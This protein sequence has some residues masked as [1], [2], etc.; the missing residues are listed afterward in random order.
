MQQAHLGLI[1]VPLGE[2]LASQDSWAQAGK[3]ERQESTDRVHS[4]QEFRKYEA[5]VSLEQRQRYKDDFNAEYEGYQNLYFKIDKII[6]KFRQFQEQWKSLTPGSKAYQVKKDETMKT[7]LHH[8]SAL[9]SL[10][11]LSEQRETVELAYMLRHCLGW[12]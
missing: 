12:V 8:S 9:D 3:A 7:V 11:L 1:Q 2:D 5:I 10:E 6:K 4:A